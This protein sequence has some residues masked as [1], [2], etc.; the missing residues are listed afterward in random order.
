MR[1]STV[2]SA[3]T[4]AA[5][6]AGCASIAR[7]AFQ[8]PVVSVR[9]VRLN[10]IGLTGGSV[11]VGLNVY[12]PNN[13][14]LDATRITYQL[15]FDTVTFAT[16]ALTQQQTVQAR[17]TLRLTIPVNFTYRG[18]G[19]AGRQI[20]GTGTVNYRL[21]GDVTVGSPLGNFTIPYSTTG[22]FSTLGGNR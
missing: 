3:F 8:E 7:Q 11:D 15:L 19:E 16:G 5:A 4:L 17:D 9:D 20:L 22:R 10:G 2:L 6:V 12:N 21:A 1:R 13:Y 14:R 18:V